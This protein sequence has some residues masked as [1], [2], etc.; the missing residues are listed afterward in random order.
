MNLEDTTCASA[1]NFT[2][3]NLNFIGMSASGAFYDSPIMSHSLKSCSTIERMKRKRVSDA[4]L[5]S[6]DMSRV[7]QRVNFDLPIFR[8]NS[9]DEER[10]NME[11]NNTCEELNRLLDEIEYRSIATRIH[12][13]EQKEKLEEKSVCMECQ[14]VYIH[15]EPRTA[16]MG[17]QVDLAELGHHIERNKSFGSVHLPFSVHQFGTHKEHQSTI[18]NEESIDSQSSYE[19]IMG[20]YI[21]MAKQL[22]AVKSENDE[23]KQQLEERDKCFH[24][25]YL[26]QSVMKQNIEIITAEKNMLEKKVRESQRAMSGSMLTT[27]ANTNASLSNPSFK[28]EISP[29]SPT[30]KSP[31]LLGFDTNYDKVNRVLDET[32]VSRLQRM[33][34]VSTMQNQALAMKVEESRVHRSRESRNRRWST[35]VSDSNTKADQIKRGHSKLRELVLAKQEL[36]SVKNRIEQLQDDIDNNQGASGYLSHNRGEVHQM[37]SVAQIATNSSG[38]LSKQTNHSSKPIS[39]SPRHHYIKDVYLSFNESGY[40]NVTAT[41]EAIE[42]DSSDPK[43]KRQR[44]IFSQWFGFPGQLKASTP[45][46]AQS[47]KLGTQS[48]GGISLVV[49]PPPVNFVPNRSPFPEQV[50]KCLSLS[51][52]SP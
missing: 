1:S 31:G 21:F 24:T 6:H 8:T 29:V 40:L 34:L 51:F 49:S 52:E 39:S 50:R 19:E 16:D 25:L 5:G 28:N 9:I 3:E 42:E 30:N 15:D 23:L 36:R 14:K 2:E 45:I 13:L 4:V 17:C 37:G 38:P 12:I 33:L 10:D 20:K 22:D 46:K 43:P 44:K 48:R 41:D 27:I 32:D 7:T 18:R 26:N 35:T 11:M 47:T